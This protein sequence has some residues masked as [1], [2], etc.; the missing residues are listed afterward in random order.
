MN[1]TIVAELAQKLVA[2]CACVKAGNIQWQYKHDHAIEQIMNDAPSGSGIDAGTQLD[3][4]KSDGNKLV[5]HTSYH[6]MNES[7]MYDGWTEHTI[8]VKAHLYHSITLHIGGRNRNDIKGYLHELFDTWL[9]SEVERG[10]HAS[11]SD[12]QEKV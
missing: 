9:Q 6:H 1:K 8:T 7:G 2:Y 11:N 3:W 5:R 4:E 10:H 12:G